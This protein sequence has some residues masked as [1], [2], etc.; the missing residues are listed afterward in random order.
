MHNC[1]MSKIFVS[2][3]A[4]KDPCIFDT[5]KNVYDSAKHKDN[6]TFGICVQDSAEVCARLKESFSGNQFKFLEVPE[7]NTQ[8]VC[9]ARSCI[10]KLITSESYYL[11]VDSHTRLCTHWNQVLLLL[12]TKCTTKKSLISSRLTPMDMSNSKKNVV[13]DDC[14]YYMSCEQFANQ[15]KVLYFPKAIKQMSPTVQ[16]WHTVSAHFIFAHTDW[17]RDVPYDPDM[18]MD[19]EDSLALRTWTHG[20]DVYY[21][22][23]KIGYHY[24]DRS[25]ARFIYVDD[26]E[27]KQKQEIAM[28]KMES[29]VHTQ[30]MLGS[31]RTLE[32]YTEYT[33][34]DYAQHRISTPTTTISDYHEYIRKG[35]N[36]V[37]ITSGK[38]H[39][40][41]R[42]N[43]EK[44]C[45]YHNISYVMYT[46]PQPRSLL[47]NYEEVGKLTMYAHPGVMFLC[48]TTCS[49]FLL[50]RD[51]NLAFV[52]ARTADDSFL[53]ASTRYKNLNPDVR[54]AVRDYTF[55]GDFLQNV[56]E[57]DERKMMK[58]NR[59]ARVK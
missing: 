20:W 7:G 23:I 27:W 51:V 5:I 43:H 6:L 21:P 53:V 56:S 22:N 26:P 2:I 24:Y 58:I 31:V 16:H 44:F 9:W 42:K 52:G 30:E 55:W 34:I 40:L 45:K 54:Y 50:R 35:T 32:S 10:Q 41:V 25:D 18:Y 57:K 12:I 37:M 47:S 14:A 8:G 29:I 39:P 4:Y 3:A 15:N 49:E 46:E 13:C 33:G 38:V 1:S 59:L 36:G 19:S 17:T 28:K 48:K 11:Q